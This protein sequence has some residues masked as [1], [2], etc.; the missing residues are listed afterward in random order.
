MDASSAILLA[1]SELLDQFLEDVKN[2]VMMPP[3][4]EE[5]CGGRDS[6]D[7]GMIARAIGEGRILVKAPNRSVTKRLLSDFGLD[8]GEAA[9][10][11]V[12]LDTPDVVVATDDRRAINACKVLRLPFVTAITV[13]TRLRGKEML[14]RD[15]AAR[16]LAILIREGR[17]S[18][19]IV[20]AV[21]RNLG[22]QGR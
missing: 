9:A 11:A 20:A 7:A 5:E 8:L 15:Q 12:A 13:L 2:P 14:S 4:V 3:E 1:K 22:M 10:L 17:Y 6:L 19:T 21:R 16:K 18:K